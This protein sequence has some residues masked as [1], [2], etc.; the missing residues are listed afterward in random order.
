[1]QRG[2]GD[3]DLWPEAAK[4]RVWDEAVALDSALD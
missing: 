4:D 2:M 3:S 1:M